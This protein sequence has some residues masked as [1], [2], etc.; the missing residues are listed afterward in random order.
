MSDNKKMIPEHIDDKL[1][2]VKYKPDETTHL[3][4]NQEDCSKCQDQPC[5]YICPANVYSWDEE[6]K[7]ILVGYENCLE[8][9]ACRIACSKTSLK[10]DYPKS[11]CGVT[12]KYG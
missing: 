7:K 9:G 1:F 11:G 3:C 10:W 6:Q 12:F 2:T 8:C 4:P 5:T